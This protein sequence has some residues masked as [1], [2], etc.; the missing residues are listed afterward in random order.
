MRIVKN[1]YIFL[2]WRMGIPFWKVA[3]LSKINQKMM[4]KTWK[5]WKK[6]EKN[7]KKWKTCRTLVVLKPIHR[8]IGYDVSIAIW[9]FSQMGYLLVLDKDY[10]ADAT[11]DYAVPGLEFVVKIRWD[12]YLIEIVTCMKSVAEFSVLS[13]VLWGAQIRLVFLPYVCSLRPK[14]GCFTS[15]RKCGSW[16]MTTSISAI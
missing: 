14:V 13:I 4:W 10:E 5:K 11:S 6:M 2:P 8:Y 7:G 1:V 3:R 9:M 16:T 12:F 15:R